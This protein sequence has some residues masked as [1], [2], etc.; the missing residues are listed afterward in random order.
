MN[1]HKAIEITKL[2][3]CLQQYGCSPEKTGYIKRSIKNYCRAIEIDPEDK[4]AYFNLGIAFKI[5]GLW[6]AIENFLKTIEIDTEDKEVYF[7]LGNALYTIE[8]MEGEI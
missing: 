7:K 2:F 8:F 4:D 3:K 1:F 6:K 5:T